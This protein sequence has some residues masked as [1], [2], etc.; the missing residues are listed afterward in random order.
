[1]GWDG[2]SKQMPRGKGKVG[3]LRYVGEKL[4]QSCR[5]FKSIKPGENLRSCNPAPINP[6][7][8]KLILP[9]H[10]EVGHKGVGEGSYGAPTLDICQ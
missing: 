3:G 5:A 2:I 7:R 1:M 4:V 9:T 10:K 8:G 6:K